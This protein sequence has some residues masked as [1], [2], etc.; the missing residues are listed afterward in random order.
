MEGA[1][2]AAAIPPASELLAV[3]SR[4]PDLW[5]SEPKCVRNYMSLND[6]RTWQGQQDAYVSCSFI[7]MK[8]LKCVGF[9][10]FVYC[11]FNEKSDFLE[12]MKEN[13]AIF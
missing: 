12:R 13:P 11:F 5:D 7:Y 2:F 10:S 6:V 9:C 3:V 8:K 1:A 4:A